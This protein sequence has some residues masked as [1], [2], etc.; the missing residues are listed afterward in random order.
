[1]ACGAHSEVSAIDEDA[2]TDAEQCSAAETVGTDG[3]GGSLV[4]RTRCLAS[5]VERPCALMPKLGSVMASFKI[6]SAIVLGLGNLRDWTR[7]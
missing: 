7:W 5:K 2:P 4:T 1:M 6:L 3:T